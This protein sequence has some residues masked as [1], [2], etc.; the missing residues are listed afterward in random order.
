MKQLKEPKATEKVA[1]KTARIT[2]AEKAETESFGELLIPIKT[3][4]TY[5]IARQGIIAIAKI[6]SLGFIS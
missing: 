6:V 4:Q 1:K 5:H 3:K 2:S